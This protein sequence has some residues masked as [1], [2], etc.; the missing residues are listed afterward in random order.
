MLKGSI[1]EKLTSNHISLKKPLNLGVYYKNTLVAL[2][3]ALEDFVLEYEG[4]PLIVAAFQ[5]GKWYLQEADRYTELAKKASDIVILASPEAGF[6]THPTGQAENVSLV[7]LSKQDPVAQEWH[8]MIF[9]PNYSA[10]VLCQELS[11]ED[12]GSDGQPSQDLERKFYG[13][14]TFESD[15]VKETIELTIEHIQTLQPDLAEAIATSLEKISQTKEYD[16]TPVVFKVLDYL[17]TSQQNLLIPINP[18]NDTFSQSLDDNLSSN[19]IQAFLRMAQII[20]QADAVKPNGAAEVASLVEAMGQILD[21][22][23]WQIKRLRLA[24]LLHRLPILKTGKSSAE[25][26]NPVQQAVTEKPESFPQASLLRIMPQLEAIAK[27]ITHQSEFWDGSGGPDALSYDNI[28]LESRILALIADFQAKSLYYQ[29]QAS[30]NY[31]REAL[32][33]CQAKASSLYDPKLVQA[34]ELLVFG[35]Q[36]GMNLETNQPKISSGMWLLEEEQQLI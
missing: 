22:P 2:C 12:Y 36:Q 31:L 30:T 10:M 8:L 11:E 25:N 5:R 4:Q 26:I 17:E 18:Y 29:K 23:A 14:W 19:K 32:A 1:L 35:L 3:H 20:D 24:A 15:L 13:F 16:L 7:S 33:D 21:L 28:P 9:S 27:I 34:L 6:I